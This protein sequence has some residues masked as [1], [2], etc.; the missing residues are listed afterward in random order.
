MKTATHL[1]KTGYWITVQSTGKVN[2]IIIRDSNLYPDNDERSKRPS[3]TIVSINDKKDLKQI[4][5]L[6]K[7]IL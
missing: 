3:E 1:T 2:H 5:K 7:E 4:M 6:F